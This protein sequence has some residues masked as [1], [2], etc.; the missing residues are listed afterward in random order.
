MPE[1]NQDSTKIV[2]F[3]VVEE[4]FSSY[5]DHLEWGIKEKKQKPDNGSALL[6]DQHGVPELAQWFGVWLFRR[7]SCCNQE[8]LLPDKFQ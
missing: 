8:D 3:W 7:K 2:Q 1:M 4:C 6:E 5:F